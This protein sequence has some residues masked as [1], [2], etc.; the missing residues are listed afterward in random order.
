MDRNRFMDIIYKAE[1]R[2][3]KE[4]LGMLPILPV[5]KTAADILVS[6]ILWQRRYEIIFSHK[7]AKAYFGEDTWKIGKT[8][9]LMLNWKRHLQNMILE[10]DPFKY[11][12]KYL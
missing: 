3:Y 6:Q 10:K 12:E 7:F 9:T 5:C 8:D 1:E 11:L 4:H 2:G